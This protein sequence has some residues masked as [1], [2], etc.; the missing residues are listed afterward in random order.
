[1]EYSDLFVK[2]KKKCTFLA[3]IMQGVQTNSTTVAEK[4]QM[5]SKNC[6]V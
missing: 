6:T 4:L 3:Y 1:M 2:L 5:C